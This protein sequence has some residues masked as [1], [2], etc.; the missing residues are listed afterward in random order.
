MIEKFW[1]KIGENLA[2]EWK[3]QDLALPLFFWG[4]VFCFGL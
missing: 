4:G 2:G 3:V 1:E